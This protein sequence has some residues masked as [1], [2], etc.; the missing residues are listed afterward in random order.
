MFDPT[1]VSASYASILCWGAKRGSPSMGNLAYRASRTM[2]HIPSVMV[3]KN[4]SSMLDLFV[5]MGEMHH[6]YEV[7]THGNLSTHVSLD[8]TEHTVSLGGECIW[9]SGLTSF[10]WVLVNM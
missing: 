5:L 6:Q 3:C 9:P 2:A 7:F 10:T 4:F 1:N 8:G